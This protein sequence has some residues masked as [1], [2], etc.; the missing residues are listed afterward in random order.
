LSANFAV[1]ER[2]AMDIEVKA[3]GLE[4]ID[5]RVGKWRRRRAPIAA[6]R[7]RLRQWKYDWSADSDRTAVYMR[8][9]A[10]D[11]G[12]RDVGRENFGVRIEIYRAAA[13]SSTRVGGNFLRP[14][15]GGH[16]CA[17]VVIAPAARP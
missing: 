10:D 2:C 7:R 14:G 5:L 12:G 1:G 3:A 8:N 17:S 13:G 15:K 4:Q 6:A 9:G 11:A 16:E